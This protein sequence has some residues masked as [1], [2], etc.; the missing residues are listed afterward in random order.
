MKKNRIIKRVSLITIGLLILNGCAGHKNDS[1]TSL[2]EKVF[3]SGAPV[4]FAPN[5]SNL[6]EWKLFD[7]INNEEVKPCK[8]KDLEA[9]YSKKAIEAE[10]CEVSVI[11]ENGKIL[12]INKNGERI[13]PQDVVS[14]TVIRHTGSICYTF[15]NGTQFTYCFNE[16]DVQ[17]WCN[18]NNNNH[19]I[20]NLL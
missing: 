1:L 16:A 12:L 3:N 13:Q 7:V 10:E 11:E 17:A 20:C 19:P 4:V 9:T 2:G 18:A 6:H 5:A 15:K 8:Q 14:L